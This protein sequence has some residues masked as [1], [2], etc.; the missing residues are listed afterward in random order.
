M[1]DQLEAEAMSLKE[2]LTQR[3]PAGA[4]PA[5]LRGV[6]LVDSQGFPRGDIDVHD[7][8]IKRNRLACIDTDHSLLMKEIETLLFTLHA[9][10][11]LLP[12]PK[13]E[14]KNINKACQQTTLSS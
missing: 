2:I 8:T 7:V 5:G 1:G 3:G 10:S 6:S 11:K 9:K 13:K 12:K 14:D 4:P